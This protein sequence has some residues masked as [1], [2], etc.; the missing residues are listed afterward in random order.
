[1]LGSSKT[2]KGTRVKKMKKKYVFAVFK[3][4][5][6]SSIFG[7]IDMEF[8]LIFYCGVLDPLPKKVP[9][10]DKTEKI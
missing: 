7:Q 5:L 6:L 8:L 4:P 1:M 10:R 3:L 2:K 9:K